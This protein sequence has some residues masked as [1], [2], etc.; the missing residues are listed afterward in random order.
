MDATS[1]YEQHEVQINIKI[2]LTVAEL[3]LCVCVSV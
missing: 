2:Y 1:L 3:R